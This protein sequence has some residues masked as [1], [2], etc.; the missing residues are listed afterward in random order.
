MTNAPR[1]AQSRR[2]LGLLAC[3]VVEIARWFVANLA[4]GKL[5]VLRAELAACLASL[6]LRGVGLGWLL[7]RAGF[8]RSRLLT[9]D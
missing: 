3:P 1:L 9:A 5:L 8:L 7:W 2:D 6:I 4:L